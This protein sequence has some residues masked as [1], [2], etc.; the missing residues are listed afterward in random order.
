MIQELA[1]ADAARQV[2]VSVLRTRLKT[3][4]IGHE[5]ILQQ[6][7]NPLALLSESEFSDLAAE[8]RRFAVIQAVLVCCQNWAENQKPHRW[9]GLWSCR[10]R[11]EDFALAIAEFRNYRYGGSTFPRFSSATQSEQ[12]RALGGPIL[13]RLL[14]FANGNYDAPL[15]LTQWRYFCMAEDDGRCHIENEGERDMREQVDKHMADILAEQAKKKEVPC[16]P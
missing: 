3:Y 10:V 2:P 16:Q 4:S 8:Q 1:F 7:R 14:N 6:K 12:G 5:I 9:M 15:A 13:C 11:M